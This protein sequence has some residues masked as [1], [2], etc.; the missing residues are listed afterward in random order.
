MNDWESKKLL[1]L[2]RELSPRIILNNRMD[3]PDV[4][5]S[6]IELILK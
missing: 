1:K 4:I 6:V 2:I 3:L 5:V